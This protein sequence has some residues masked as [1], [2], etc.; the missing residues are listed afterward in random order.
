MVSKIDNLMMLRVSVG[1]I[2]LWFGLLKFFPNL[3]PA[4]ELAS[5]TIKWL[6]HGFIPH[7]LGMK[8]L[9]LWEILIGLGLMFGIYLKEVIY[10]FLLH[11]SLT[12]LPLFIFQD[13]TFS[14]APYGLTLT[15]QYIIKNIVL[16]AIGV[17]LLLYYKR[18]DK[19]HV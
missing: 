13:I 12:F 17:T 11:I 9:A 3:S 6:F 1:F 5:I 16:L 14:K 4:E 15:G 19:Q 18:K 10:L 7:E 8:A 2:F